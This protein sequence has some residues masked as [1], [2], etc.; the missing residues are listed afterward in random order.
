MKALKELRDKEL[1]KVNGGG[2]DSFEYRPEDALSAPPAVIIKKKDPLA[3]A[4]QV[5]TRLL[6]V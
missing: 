3:D 5:R 1:A 2:V 4:L 6:H